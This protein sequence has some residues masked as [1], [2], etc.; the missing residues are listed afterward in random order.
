MS[1]NVKNKTIKWTS[2][3]RQQSFSYTYIALLCA[4]KINLNS[5]K[6]YT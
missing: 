5:L 3:S 4:G 2:T 6:T 1:T